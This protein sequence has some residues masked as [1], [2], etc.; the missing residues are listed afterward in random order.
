MSKKPLFWQ[1]YFPYLSLLLIFIVYLF[2]PFH[3]GLSVISGFIIITSIL[4]YFHTK[5]I[6][7]SIN[8]LRQGARKLSKGDFDIRLAECG[9][10]ELDHLAHAMNLMAQRL[11]EKIKDITKHEREKDAIL[12]GISEGLIAID[13]NQRILEINKAASQLF[14]ISPDTSKGKLIPEV[15]RS[16]ELQELM[17]ETL[18]IKGSL[19]EEVILHNEDDKKTYLQVYGNILE[20]EK[21]ETIGAVFVLSD[22]TRIRRLENIR[23]DFVANVSHELKTPV[24]SIKGFVETLQ[25]GAIRSPEDASKF[26]GII[27]KHTNRLTNI[28]NDLLTLARLEEYEERKL[29]P[30]NKETIS[31]KETI[32]NVIDVCE[33][34]AKEKQIEVSISCMEQISFSAH[35]SLIEQALINLLS[36]A[37]KYSEPKTTVELTCL[38]Q[39]SKIIFS[40]KDQGPGIPDEHLERVFERFYRVDKARSRSEGGTGLGLAIVKHI[41]KVHGGEVA[42]ISE[43]GKGSAFSISIPI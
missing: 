9:I 23:K 20:T 6:T 36:N 41:A 22:I 31:A 5:N 14:G 34:T 28:I 2:L 10:D 29:A 42:V 13:A 21:K 27:E 3:L 17:K 4:L 32:S 26:L 30:I 18:S 39:A 16:F 25:N 33:M 12:S 1:I 24:T 35:R 7:E 8:H 37:I 11:D 43:I 15:I 19:S 40:V 38:K